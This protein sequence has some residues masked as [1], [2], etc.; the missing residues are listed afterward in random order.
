MHGR[1]TSKMVSSWSLSRTIPVWDY[2]SHFF[3]KSN[4]FP[5]ADQR[6]WP[7]LFSRGFNLHIVLTRTFLSCLLLLQ[8]LDEDYR[9]NRVDD[10]LQLFTSICSN[11]ILTNSHLILMLNKVCFFSK[12]ISVNPQKW[13]SPPLLQ[14]DVLRAKILAGIK[15]K[16]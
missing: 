5:G 9:T 10:S 1:T 12:R 11:K 13:R 2:S 7:G 3:S 14:T 6:F 15:V 4:H 16:K 8:Y